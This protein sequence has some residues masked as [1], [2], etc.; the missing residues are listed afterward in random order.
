MSVILRTERGAIAVNK[1]VLEKMIIEDLLELSDSVVLCSKKGKPIYQKNPGRIDPD[2]Y[3]A[4][5]IYEKKHEVKVKLFIISVYGSAVSAVADKI[6]SI[7]ESDFG[8]LQL[9]RPGSISVKVKGIMVS[10]ELVKR[11]IE[12][13]RKN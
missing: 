12:L 6:F 7:I 8:L 10:G 2:L 13:L 5:E 1:G 11:N 4:L 3:D 9:D